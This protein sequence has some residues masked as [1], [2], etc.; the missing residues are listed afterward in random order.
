[1]R[2]LGSESKCQV[3]S[4]CPFHRCLLLLDKF[5]LC[6]HGQEVHMNIRH[7]LSNICSVSALLM[8]F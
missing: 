6:D 4:V 2:K 3:I 7:S 1:M 5:L 8:F